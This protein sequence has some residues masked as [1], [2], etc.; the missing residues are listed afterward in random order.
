MVDIS[1]L[2]RATIA[3]RHGKRW[4]TASRLVTLVWS[5]K[6][7]WGIENDPSI[8]SVSHEEQKFDQFLTLEWKPSDRTSSIQSIRNLEGS[9]S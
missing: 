6:N 1:A 8:H 9:C 3:K 7:E 4:T 5:F 2:E